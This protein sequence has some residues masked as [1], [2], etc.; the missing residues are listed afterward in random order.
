[1][2]AGVKIEERKLKRM[3]NTSHSLERLL[4]DSFSMGSGGRGGRKEKQKVRGRTESIGNVAAIPQ[5]R[6]Q[7]ACW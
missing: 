5:Q 7:K 6:C 1:M 3:V 4:K 2:I